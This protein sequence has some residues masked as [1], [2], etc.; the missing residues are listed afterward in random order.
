MTLFIYRSYTQTRR[1]ESLL[2]AS[3]CYRG[4]RPL[5]AMRINRYKELKMKFETLFTQLRPLLVDKK[6]N[7]SEELGQLFSTAGKLLDQA[8]WQLLSDLELYV[9]PAADDYE[10]SGM[11]DDEERLD[12]ELERLLDLFDDLENDLATSIQAVA[13]V[14]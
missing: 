1:L 8:K 13:V 11:D 6:A 9:Q 10:E 14:T 7:S 2:I 5:L 3:A 4:R 12:A